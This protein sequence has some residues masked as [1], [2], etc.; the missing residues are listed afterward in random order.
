MVSLNLEPFIMDIFTR[1]SVMVCI[2]RKIVF[3]VSCEKEMKITN[4][5]NRVSQTS[6]SDVDIIT[7]I[8]LNANATSFIHI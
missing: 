8:N 2:I 1:V 4:N 6:V 5:K 7:I 3:E